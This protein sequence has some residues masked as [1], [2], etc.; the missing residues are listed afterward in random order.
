MRCSLRTHAGFLE[1]KTKL[2]AARTKFMEAKARMTKLVTS[3]VGKALVDKYSKLAGDA[4]P[5][6]NKLLAL[7]AEG[8]RDEAAA[9]LL[10]EARPAYITTLTAMDDIVKYERDVAAKAAQEAQAASSSARTLMTVLGALALVLG[11]IVAWLITRSITAPIKDAVKVAEKVAQGDLSARIDVR[12]SDE[13]GQLL[14]P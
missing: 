12:S 13:T 9:V 4:V 11:A 6:N 14:R 5:I 7:R 3:D 8:K 2:A 10:N 1:E